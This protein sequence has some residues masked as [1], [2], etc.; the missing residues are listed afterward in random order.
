MR[1]VDTVPPNDP[2]P[3][4]KRLVSPFEMGLEVAEDQR[5]ITLESSMI[6]FVR[7]DGKYTPRKKSSKNNSTQK[8]KDSRQQLQVQLSNIHFAIDTTPKL[9]RRRSSCSDSPRE[10]ALAHGSLRSCQKS[11]QA[12]HQGEKRVTFAC[13][14]QI[15]AP[16]EVYSYPAIP[17]SQRAELFWSRE[18]I[19]N[20]RKENKEIASKARLRQPDLL[21]SILCLHG[22]TKGDRNTVVDDLRSAEIEQSTQLN[23]VQ[24]S[25]NISQSGIR[26]IE[27]FYTNRICRHR[28]WAI[29]KILSVQRSCQGQDPDR[30]ATLLRVWSVKVS[31]APT[32]YANSVALGDEREAMGAGKPISLPRIYSPQLWDVRDSRDFAFAA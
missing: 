17:L 12:Q 22:V 9:P 21:K 25:R 13:D 26:G 19:A 2:V 6:D 20:I 32:R 5:I 31:D 29:E 4:T 28:G 14:S 24:A 8:K 3:V 10:T 16:E 11:R 15:N 30:I 23:E 18:E 1:Q 27:H 7:A